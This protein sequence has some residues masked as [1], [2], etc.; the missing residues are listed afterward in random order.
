MVT[1]GPLVSCT[2]HRELTD[3]ELYSQGTGRCTDLSVTTKMS[4][5]LNTLH[6]FIDDRNRCYLFFSGIYAMSL[7]RVS[8]YI[9]VV[10]LITQSLFCREITPGK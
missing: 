5:G 8:S 6:A 10:F 2:R 9:M 3:N 4:K 7:S 1:S